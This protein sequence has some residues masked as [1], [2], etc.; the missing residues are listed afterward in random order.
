MNGQLAKKYLKKISS[1][2][3]HSAI[4][5]VN[6]TNVKGPPKTQ[7][8]PKTATLKGLPSPFMYWI[9]EFSRRFSTKVLKRGSL[10]SS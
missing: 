4:G 9:R 6:K 2:F 8:K 7:T 5:W 3:L 10:F 1:A